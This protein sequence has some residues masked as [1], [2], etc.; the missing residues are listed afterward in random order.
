[1]G[2]AQRKTL[3]AIYYETC[4]CGAARSV[5]FE[6]QS[7]SNCFIS[8]LSVNNPYAHIR[9]TIFHDDVNGQ[10]R[11]YCFNL[12]A[13]LFACLFIGS[14]AVKKEPNLFAIIDCEAWGGTGSL[15][16]CPGAGW[17]D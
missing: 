14:Q 6:P 15:H 16:A 8:Q 5:N 10:Y 12:L 17:L 2:A 3:H 13:R 1:M 7:S 4:G 11:K 9:L